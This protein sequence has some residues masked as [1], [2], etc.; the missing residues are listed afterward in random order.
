[1]SMWPWPG[2]ITRGFRRVTSLNRNGESAEYSVSGLPA[3][4][5][6][7]AVPFLWWFLF[8]PGTSE[9]G[10][11]PGGQ[12][13]GGVESAGSTAQPPVTF[14][15]QPDGLPPAAKALSLIVPPERLI[16]PPLAMS[17]LQLVVHLLAAYAP[18]RESQLSVSDP[19]LTVKPEAP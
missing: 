1:M 10:L 19:A 8:P 13:M 15:E 9:L 11:P 18:F 17:P 3:L 16:A 14:P 5:L 4:L 6:R 2:G 12:A 7:L